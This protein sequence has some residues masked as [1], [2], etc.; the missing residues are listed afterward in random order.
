MQKK[1]TNNGTDFY[2]NC[3]LSPVSSNSLP[4][5][6]HNLIVVKDVTLHIIA[7]HICVIDYG[8]VSFNIVRHS[9]IKHNIHQHNAV[10]DIDNIYRCRLSFYIKELKQLFRERQLVLPS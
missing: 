10:L 6:H 2:Y 7:G 5:T 8:I 4:S 3:I 9:I 1:N